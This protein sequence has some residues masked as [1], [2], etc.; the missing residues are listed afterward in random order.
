M[1]NK[2]PLVIAD[3]ETQLS[4]AISAG[5][6]SFTLSSATDDDGNALAAGKYCF[7]VN[8]G[9]SNKQYLLG[10]LN[11]TAVTSV[12][13]VDRR[14]NE[15]S[16]AASSARS[17]SPVII[18]DFA[19]IQR[20]ADILRGQV[21]LDGSNPI[22][23]DAT[24]TISNAL[25]LATKAYV[26]SVVT[27][28]T[29]VSD[30]LI[31]PSA[32]TIAGEAV[33][34]GDWVFFDTS[35]QE[36]YLIDADTAAEVDAAYIGV[37]LGTGSDGVAITGG[38]QTAGVYTTTGLTAGA[39]YY[40]SNTA[41]EISSSAG[42]TERAIGVALSTTK[43]LMNFV[44]KRLP[45][46][47]EK[48]ALAG[49]GAPPSATNPYTTK[50][51]TMTSGETISGATTPV[52]V[53]QNKTDNEFYACDANDTDKMKFLGF[54]VSNGTDGNDIDVQ[55]AGI[56]PGFTGLSEGEKYYVQDTAGTIGT[57]AGTYEV[58]VGV[59]ISETEL[60]IQKGK[61]RAGGSTYL[62]SIDAT[63]SE[64]IT[65]G[66]R[67]SKIRVHVWNRESQSANIEL[68]FIWV[69][70]TA[71]GLSKWSSGSGQSMEDSVKFF[72]QS[73]SDY[74]TFSITSVTDTG[75]TISYTETGTFAELIGY[76]WEAEGEL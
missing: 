32:Q 36:W 53:Y 66:F 17:G 12:V 35:D 67:P 38:V 2:I 69:N 41:G 1:S 22:I 49:D 44:E 20:V 61:R 3:F 23:Y 50:N 21:A 24:P 64:S 52:P 70:G 31:I 68:N 5:A 76:V 37:A 45:T 46:A 18:S 57:T 71:H 4:G 30:N 58:L 43:L 74:L 54:A 47:D 15:T 72:D 25:H 63:G 28:G 33:A 10:Q 7:T 42:T 73:G 9:R 19:T 16:G 27:G 55:F 11:G 75:F 34:A 39:V 29:L 40:L 62:G 13:S 26:D 6:T 56:V 60:L 8:N 48:D 59:A 14:G 65:T 51:R